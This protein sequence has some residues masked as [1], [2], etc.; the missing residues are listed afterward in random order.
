M[1]ILTAS[2]NSNPCAPLGGAH[3]TRSLRSNAS[4]KTALIAG[5]FLVLGLL[6][7][8]LFYGKIPGIAFPLYI[9]LVTAGFF[10]IASF[11]KKQVSKLN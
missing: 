9:I 6:F 4:P 8:Y 11:F 7:D 1:P 3:Y 2:L 5:V 10:T